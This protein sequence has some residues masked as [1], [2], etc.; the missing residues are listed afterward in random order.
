[1]FNRIIG[2][3]RQI[4][5]MEELIECAEEGMA[6]E[7]AKKDSDENAVTAAYKPRIDLFNGKIVEAV[8]T[9]F[10]SLSLPQFDFSSNLKNKIH[11]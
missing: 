8:P 3:E 2:L 6:I 11:Q 1:M 9:L 10:I 5:R 4:Q 7:L